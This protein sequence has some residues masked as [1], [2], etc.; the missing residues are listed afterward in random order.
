MTVGRPNRSSTESH[1]EDLNVVAMAGYSRPVET[2]SR[3]SGPRR[4][5]EIAGTDAEAFQPR[6]QRGSIDAEE[7]GS[8]AAPG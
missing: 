1:V 5:L 3:H 7:I 2:V 6:G 4:L 8:A